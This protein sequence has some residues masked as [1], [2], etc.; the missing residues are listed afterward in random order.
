MK[1]WY[2][3]FGAVPMM[4]GLL[5]GSGNAYGYTNP[6][7]AEYEITQQTSKVTGV[8]VDASGVQ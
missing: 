3:L 5:A 7:H 1:D 2:R 8:V 6:L 4:L